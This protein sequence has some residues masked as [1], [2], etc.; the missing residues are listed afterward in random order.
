MPLLLEASQVQPQPFTVLP[1]LSL[2]CLRFG[3]RGI[4]N[5]TFL[6]GGLKVN[7]LKE[8]IL[9]AVDLQNQ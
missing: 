9:V 7:S 5:F 2:K 4:I 3:L 8:L 6:Q 1:A